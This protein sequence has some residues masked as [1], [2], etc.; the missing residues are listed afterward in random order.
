MAFIYIAKCSFA[1]NTSIYTIFYTTNYLS[2]CKLKRICAT[3]AGFNCQFVDFKC[4]GGVRDIL[5]VF[6]FIFLL[7][8]DA[9]IMKNAHTYACNTLKFFQKI[10]ISESSQW[11]KS[12]DIEKP[13]VQSTL[14]NTYIKPFI[15]FVF[16][17]IYPF[18]TI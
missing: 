6:F 9:E 17:L 18:Y 5:I 3:I 14:V 11:F 2:F 7:T 8:I 15:L 10:I 1:Y 4:D 13:M 16:V 12:K